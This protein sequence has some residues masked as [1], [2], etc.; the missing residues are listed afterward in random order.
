MLLELA[1]DMIGDGETIL[2]SQPMLQPAH[3][4]AGTGSARRQSRIGARRRG[5]SPALRM[6]LG[7]VLEMAESSLDRATYEQKVNE[8][9]GV[10]QQLDLPM[11]MPTSEQRQEAAN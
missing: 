5:S 9:F 1:H 11:P 10:E 2:V 7:R 8:R 6:Y 3:D 4:L